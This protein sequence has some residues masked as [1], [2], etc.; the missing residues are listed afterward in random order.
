MTTVLFILSDSSVFP[1]LLHLCCVCLQTALYSCALY[2]DA[3]PASSGGVIGCESASLPA[4]YVSDEVAEIS[5][6]K[7]RHV[8]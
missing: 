3:G 8:E 7:R 5:L 4:G 6:A 2:G 1:I